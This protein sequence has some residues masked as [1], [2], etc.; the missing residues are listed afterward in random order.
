[1]VYVLLPLL[2][3]TISVLSLKHFTVGDVAFFCR[4]RKLS[5]IKTT[6]LS[7]AVLKSEGKIKFLY[8]LLFSALALLAM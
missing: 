6:G 4:E 2:R 8:K 3:N 7:E 5:E 1:M